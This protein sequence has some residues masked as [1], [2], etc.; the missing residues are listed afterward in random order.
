M[1]S[2]C[3]FLFSA[4]VCVPSVGPTLEALTAGI[5]A[6]Q[7][8][9]S[10]FVRYPDLAWDVVFALV[11]KSFS[12]APTRFEIIAPLAGCG[13]DSQGARVF[14]SQTPRAW[15]THATVVA[16]P[17][18]DALAE[19]LARQG[20]RHWYH[21]PEGSFRRIWLGSPEGD[22]G[23]YDPSVDGGFRFEF[24]PSDSEAFTPKLFQH[25]VD[26]PRPGETGF[27]RIKH[28][29][30]L[31][32]D[33]DAS[34]RRLETLFGWDAAGAVRDEPGRGYRFVEMSAN[35][36]HGAVLKLV[37]PTDPDGRAARDLKAEGPG[38]YTIGIAAYDL[39]AT[40]ADLTD[41][42]V[43]FDR[44]P[45]GSAEPETLLI[46]LPDLGAPIA[47]TPDR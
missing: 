14:A 15:R 2:I 18:I 33:I 20:V 10:A 3:D 27:R 17:C 45:A 22:V 34:L 13:E 26:E 47:L 29:A 6:P 38:P 43:T 32:A 31:V 21:Y 12:A 44:L 30:F 46:T 7:P 35:F 41:R 5:G 25:P 42:G 4:D 40:A 8:G 28:R 9:P 24:I 19:R 16:T 1:A 23:D 11:N 37:Q 36:T 39:A